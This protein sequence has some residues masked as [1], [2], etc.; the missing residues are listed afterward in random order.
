MQMLS[1]NDVQFFNKFLIMKNDYVL[2]PK[3]DL[4]SIIR[5]KSC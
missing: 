1:K 2:I 5:K 4:E 3:I